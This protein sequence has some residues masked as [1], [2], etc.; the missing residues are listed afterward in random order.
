MAKLIRLTWQ[1]TLDPELPRRDRK[2]CH[3]EAYVPDALQARP[4]QLDGE[5]AADVAEAEK[6]LAQ[7]NSHAEALATTE[8]LA[9]LLLRAESMASSR[10]EGLVVGGRRLLRAEAARELHEDPH[11]ITAEEVLGN[12]EAMVWALESVPAT[13]RISVDHLLEMHRRLLSRTHLQEEAGQ[14]RAVQNWIGGSDY[15]PC[16]AEFVPPP[17]EYA[18]AL[19]DDLCDF[20]NTDR[21][22]AV[23]Q[24]AL[25]HAQFETIHPFV[26]GNG[27]IG[28]ALI[29]LVL[30]RRGLTSRVFP[31]VSLILAT[32]S[33]EYIRRLMGTRY[34]G[35]TDSN[36]AHDGL[37]QWIALFA[38]A[39][40]RAV[41]DALVFEE[42]M[43]ALER[44]W[45][46]R[47]G[48]I[49]KHSATDLLL[50]K[51][52]GVPLITVK[53][54]TGLIDRSFQATNQAVTRLVDA[55]ILA[56]V[57]VGRRNRAFEAKDVIDTF[58]NLERQLASPTRNTRSAPPNRQ[59][60]YRQ[61][62][63]SSQHSPPTPGL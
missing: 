46:S 61:R 4:I 14:I 8:V 36:E 54:A 2:P 47:L 9:R 22:P 18:P 42:R 50:P 10:I 40:K 5:V 17:P 57:S 51:L 39:C 7:F 49:R 11:D 28:R 13:A 15:N 58:T 56:T 23:A 45:R 31:P 44:R 12:I 48:P 3:Y 53:A 26:D 29:Q 27:R 32:W 41:S 38:A 6:E 59:V 19:L 30:R 1:S 63:T 37:N 52:T 55:G 34:R 25:A 20:C 60:P 43:R 35:P 24:A 21:L 33:R 16:S 62:I